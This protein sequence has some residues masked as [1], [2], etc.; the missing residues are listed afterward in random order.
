[1]LGADEIGFSTAPLI[2]TGCIMMR[3]C[4]LNT[5]PVGIATQDPE[6]RKRFQGTPEHVV[7][8]F[9]F[10][11]EELRG[12]MASLGVRTLDEL[13]GRTDLLEVDDGDRPLEGAR[14]RPH[15]RPARRPSCPRAPPRRRVKPPPPVLDD[16]LDWKLIE[17]AAPA[18]EAEASRS[19]SRSRVRN[20]NRCVGGVLSSRDRPAP[21]RRGPAGGHDPGRLRRL[22]RPELRRLARAG[23]R[24]SRCTATPTTT[25]ARACPAASLAVLPP[26]GVDL[27]R[28]G[29]RDHRQHRPLRRDERH[30]RS[31]AACAGERFAVRNSGAQRRRRGRRR[32][33]LRVHDR[34]A[35]RRARARP[36]ATS[37]PGMSGGLAFVLD[38]DGAFRAP[39]QPDDARPARG[40][41]RG[42]RDRGCARSSPST[43]SAPGS[44]V[45]QRVLDDWDA[46]LPTLRQGLPDRLQARAR[47]AGGAAASCRGSA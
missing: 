7:N 26:D 35:R 33:R 46:L 18:V 36:G 29:E 34:R 9:F 39:R 23:R 32:P 16:D 25:P 27:R 24:P 14:R 44:P 20:V 43:C 3:A 19:R 17:Q 2:A 6:L 30:A 1:M 5:C 37:R 13:I 42:R 21:R 10:V 38:E 22:G 41:R 15:A 12:I 8:F 45:G 31:S 47:R 11:A 28:R 40:A 4:H